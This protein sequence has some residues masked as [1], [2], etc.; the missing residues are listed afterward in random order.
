[1]D[2]RIH[3]QQGQIGLNITK[4]HF[5]MKSEQP[6]MELSPV[7]PAV[8]IDVHHPRIVEIDQTQQFDE[9]GRKKH[10]S[11]AKTYANNGRAAAARGIDRRVNEGNRMADFHESVNVAR[12]TAQREQVPREKRL[13]IEVLPKTPVDIRF[14]IR[15]VQVDVRKGSVNGQLIRGRTN[16]HA[17]DGNV[18]VYWQQ[19][20]HIDI[21][22]VGNN[23]DKIF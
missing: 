23:L 17:R 15:D 11:F 10:V 9:L 2:L 14:D 21:T 4:N 19:R 3:S 8:I 5:Q 16:I 6:R 13:T 20:P 7:E 1:M 22:Y 12:I 18:D